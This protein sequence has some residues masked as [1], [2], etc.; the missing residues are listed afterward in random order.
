MVRVAEQN[1]RAT[2]ET[3]KGEAAAARPRAEGEAAAVQ[4][5][6]DGEAA[7]IR[8]VG[9]AKADAYRQGI[10]AVD[11]EGHTA[12]RFAGILGENQVKLV[13]DLAASGDGQGSAALATAMIARL[14]PP[15]RRSE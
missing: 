15:V 3:A 5:T 9:A 1:A 11:T 4:M 2:A 14:M 12:M 8:A 6:G 7:A 13:P 10:A